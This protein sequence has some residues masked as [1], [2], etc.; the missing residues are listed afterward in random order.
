MSKEL[1]ALGKNIRYKKEHIGNDTYRLYIKKND[2]EL[3]EQ[4]LQR[5]E[6]IDNAEPSEALKCLERITAY[7]L[8]KTKEMDFQDLRDI[9]QSLLKAQENEKVLEIIK[10]KNV[11]IY[12]LQECENVEQYNKKC[13]YWGVQLTQQEYDLLKRWLG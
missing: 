9:E 10:E 4:A 11:D 8:N 5:L 1:E 6:A 13:D 12:E 2:I 3:L 7:F